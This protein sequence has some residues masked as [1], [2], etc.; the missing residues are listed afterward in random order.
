MNSLKTRKV[1]LH[2]CCA[3]CAS[4]AIKRLRAEGYEVT[5]FF[6]N[7]NIYPHSEYERRLEETKKLAVRLNNIPAKAKPNVPPR[8]WNELQTAKYV[9]SISGCFLDIS[10][11]IAEKAG[12]RY[13]SLKP[14]KPTKKSFIS[15]PTKL[16]GIITNKIVI[17]INT[18]EEYT[19]N[20]L[21]ILSE[22]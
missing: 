17:V 12:I 15:I 22:I 4:E 2:I 8:F 7:P 14:T 9:L 18:I 11:I 5:G 6:Y 20:F 19:A 21:D 10:P 13:Q 3:V 16:T 1:L